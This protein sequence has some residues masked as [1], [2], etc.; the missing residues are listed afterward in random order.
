MSTPDSVRAWAG[1]LRLHSQVLPLL[2]REVTAQGGLPLSW[3]DVLRE[4]ASACGR[5]RMS[6]LGKRVVLS[7]TRVS[8]IVDELAA[9]GL[10]QREANPDDGRS[11]FAVLTPEG[12]ARQRAAAPV[13]LR[14]IEQELGRRLSPVSQRALADL[15][16]EAL[17]A[18]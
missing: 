6:E 18:G 7:R 17:D 13:Y 15:L 14:G 4:L 5:L 11:S 12:R 3:Y 8:R 10:V 16:E 1:V 9:A 2:D